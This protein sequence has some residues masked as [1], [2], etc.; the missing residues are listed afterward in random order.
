MEQMVQTLRLLRWGVVVLMVLRMVGKA[1]ECTLLLGGDLQEQLP[2]LAQYLIVAA[3]WLRAAHADRRSA[4]APRG[5]QRV[6]AAQASRFT[7]PAQTRKRP[8]AAV[9]GQRRAFAQAGFIGGG[10]LRPACRPTA[11]PQPSPHVPGVRPLRRG[12]PSSHSRPPR[13]ASTP[14]QAPGRRS[15]GPRPP[16]RAGSAV[17]LRAAALGHDGRQPP[18]AV[19]HRRAGGQCGGQRQAAVRRA[20]GHPH[21]LPA[22]RRPRP[23]CPAAHAAPSFSSAASAGPGGQRACAGGSSP[24]PVPAAAPQSR[25]LRARPA[26]AAALSAAARHASA[27]SRADCHTPAAS[28]A[29]S[30]SAAARL[31]PPVRLRQ[32]HQPLAHRPASFLSVWVIG[33]IWPPARR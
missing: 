5:A 27:R 26:P 13:R 18:P 11:R 16:A 25:G 23:R 15:N 32:R 2:Y 7:P 8:R 9:A 28:T 3:V 1:L 31:R 20:C 29:A 24:P 33:S 22:A 6:S 12:R 14:L 21:R 17:A 19:Q 10:G 4:R 30:K